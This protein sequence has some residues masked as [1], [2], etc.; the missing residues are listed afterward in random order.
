M[1]TALVRKLTK[2]ERELLEEKLKDKKMPV[3]N[4][5]R[6]RIVKEASEGRRA[7]EIA[8]R[9]GCHFTVVYDWT[10]RFNS[11]GFSTF[12]KPPNPEGRISS[13]SREQI[14]ELI[15]VAL[16]RPEDLGLPFTT[17]SVRKIN[18]YCRS[19]GILPQ[20]TDEWVRRLLRREGI[21]HQ[22]TGTWKRSPDPDFEVKK[23]A[24]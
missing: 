10:K 13:I 23:T 17:W 11:T 24:Y 16:S 9:V 19:E 22:R 18:H 6:Y 2:K 12:E 1:P 14:R 3:R 7:A 15:R 8:D 4:Y 5:E 20:V 21:T